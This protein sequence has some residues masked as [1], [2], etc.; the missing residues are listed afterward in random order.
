MQNL[1]R[2]QPHAAK[3]NLVQEGIDLLVLQVSGDE[4][5]NNLRVGKMYDLDI[6][7]VVVARADSLRRRVWRQGEVGVALVVRPRPEARVGALVHGAAEVA[8]Q[9]QRRPV[10]ASVRHARAALDDDARRCCD[11][12]RC[13]AASPLRVFVESYGL[14]YPPASFQLY[15]QAVRAR[16]RKSGTAMPISNR[17]SS[18]SLSLSLFF[19]SVVPAGIREKTLRTTRR[20]KHEQR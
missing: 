7:V 19:L 11:T 16:S 3:I 5:N 9:P 1:L 6:E 15:S 13:G 18:L 17:R 14:D 10:A 12:R 8:K 2:D 4:G 20:L